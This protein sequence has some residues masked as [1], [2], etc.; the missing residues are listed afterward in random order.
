MK[1]SLF[2]VMSLVTGMTVNLP[3]CADEL[4]SQGAFDIPFVH[5]H[6]G[7]EN[8]GFLVVSG[9]LSASPCTLK[10]QDVFL[11]PARKN[12]A[13]DLTLVGCG[14]GDAM[15][16]GS[17]G[18]MHVMQSLQLNH[19][20]GDND[21]QRAP[22]AHGLVALHGGENQLTYVLSRKALQPSQQG[23]NVHDAL[24]RLHLEYE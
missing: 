10:T 23:R 15:R 17:P 13:L 6:D 4:W 24:L 1:K 16:Q 2:L 21:G 14:E 22:L 8:V 12:I 7:E 20:D 11:S 19:P 3:V 18:T 9:A 5:V